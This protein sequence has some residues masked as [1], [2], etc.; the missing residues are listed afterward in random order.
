[1]HPRRRGPGPGP[2]NTALCPLVHP[3]AYKGNRDPGLEARMSQQSPSYAGEH[4][5]APAPLGACRQKQAESRTPADE[6]DLL[7]AFCVLLRTVPTGDRG[8]GWVVALRC[9]GEGGGADHG[10]HG[11]MGT[12]PPFL[13]TSAEQAPEGCKTALY[14]P[15]GQRPSTEYDRCEM[16][17]PTRS[18]NARQR[19]VFQRNSKFKKTAKIISFP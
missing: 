18:S 4:S 16:D 10:A 9:L 5:L 7:L 12:Q 14:K 15:L 13:G 19:L 8:A 6:T 3:S 11:S 17:P 1:M 2:F